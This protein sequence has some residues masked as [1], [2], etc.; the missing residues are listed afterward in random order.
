[1]AGF[2]AIAVSSK[3]RNSD[4]NIRDSTSS[5]RVSWSLRRSRSIDFH[6][7]TPP[8][9]PPSPPHQPTPPP[10]TNPPPTP[11]PPTPPP[12]TPPP[13]TPPPPPPSNT[14]PPPP[15]FPS[16][17]MLPSS[18]DTRHRKPPTRPFGLDKTRE[19]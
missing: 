16:S 7:N 13:H 8:P 1:M 6:Q 15:D 14:P 4:A 10:P 5:A 9:P 17:E 3:A 19:C 2:W 12:P 11:P 18:N